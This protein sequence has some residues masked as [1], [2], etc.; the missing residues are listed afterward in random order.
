[1]NN[2]AVKVI[3]NGLLVSPAPL[4]APPRENSIAINGC[5]DPINHINITDNLI[6][7]SSSIINL[8]N[9]S[10]K[11]TIIIPKIVIDN[12]DKRIAPQP[13]FFACVKSAAPKC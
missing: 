10:E 1:M 11:I 13:D 2:K 5:I 9:G 12:I 6:T 7:S 8:D 4:S 3:N